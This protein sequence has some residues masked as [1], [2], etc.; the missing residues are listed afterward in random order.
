[1]SGGRPFKYKPEY[2]KIVIDLG[3]D[4]ASLAQMA[5]ECGII[6]KTLHNWAREYKEFAEALAMACELSQVWWEK[7]GQEY[8]VD[9]GDNGKINASIY[10]RCMAARFPKDWTEKKH[11]E[12]TGKD[13]KDLEITHKVLVYEGCRAESTD[14]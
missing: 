10:S 8:L 5:I 2:C 11:S 4:G 6:R 3:R 13:G 9:T 12:I 7:A 14:T 1:M